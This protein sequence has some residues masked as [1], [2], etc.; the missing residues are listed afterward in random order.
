MMIVD[1]RVAPGHVPSPGKIAL[2]DFF[3]TGGFSEEDV[4]RLRHVGVTME[5]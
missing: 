2:P 3:G 1:R 4:A 5:R